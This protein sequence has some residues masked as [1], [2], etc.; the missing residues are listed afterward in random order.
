MPKRS[1]SV[2]VT[3]LL[4]TT[5][6]GAALI[7]AVKAAYPGASAPAWLVPA[8]FL[9]AP[10]LAVL[11]TDRDFAAVG[12]NPPES[13]KAALDIVLFAAV[14]LPLFLISWW[15]LAKYFLGFDF[16]YRLPGKIFSL[17]LWQVAGVALPEELFFRGWMQK[18]IDTLLGGRFTAFGAVIGPGLFISAV[19]FAL[20][21]FLSRPAP[22]SLLV[23]FPGMLFGLFRERTGSVLVPVVTHALAN[24]TFLVA[25]SMAGYSF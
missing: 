9:Y 2:T 21:H 13:K 1:R 15:A 7:L 6:A 12:L 16:N 11:V 5:A 14:V 20:F 10:L 24:I 17:A 18:R 23:F 3:E 8:F 25:Q 22:V 4:V 19:V